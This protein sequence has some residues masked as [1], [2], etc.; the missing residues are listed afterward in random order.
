[1]KSYIIAALGV[2]SSQARWLWPAETQKQYFEDYDSWTWIAQ[3]VDSDFPFKDQAQW[4]HQ[5]SFTQLDDQDYMNGWYQ[6]DGYL[7]IGTTWTGGNADA[8][9]IGSVS[10]WN[11]YAFNLEHSKFQST[12][13]M[14]FF[15]YVFAT[16]Y[17]Q[18]QPSAWDVP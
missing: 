12:A 6:T 14:E 16:S 17:A 18:F 4:F 15:K 5:G 3:P 9:S 13:T 2:A 1:M 8:L 10:W 7:G 11:C